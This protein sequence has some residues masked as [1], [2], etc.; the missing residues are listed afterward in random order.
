MKK[1]RNQLIV[2]L[3]SISNN[4]PLTMILSTNNKEHN[5][6]PSYIIQPKITNDLEAKPEITNE[7]DIKEKEGAKDK[8]RL[9]IKSLSL[10][11]ILLFQII[12]KEK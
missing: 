4:G 10:K 11:L 6:I 7:H 1:E 3:M 2:Q 5:F 8:N 12:Y 9:R